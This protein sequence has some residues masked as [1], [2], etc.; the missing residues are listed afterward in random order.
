MMRVRTNTDVASALPGRRVLLYSV[1]SG[2][3]ALT[4]A[5]IWLLM[6]VDEGRGVA[7]ATT[8]MVVKFTN[9]TALLVGVVAGWIASGR[10][11]GELRAVGHLTVMLMAVVTAAV[12]A[13]VLDPSLPGGWWGAVDLCQ[14]Y[15]I[16]V[17]VVA[18]W[19]T[20]GPPVAV[21]R[22]RRALVLVVPLIWLVIVLVRGG[23]S[24]SYPYDF[25]DVAENGWPS[26]LTTVAALVAFILILG[27]LF[28]AIEVRL[29]PERDGRP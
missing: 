12:N 2:L 29:D 6:I 27:A 15:V 19:A 20:M 13:I 24:D 4:S 1:L 14:H 7:S 23:F 3:A 17:M 26:V 10:S 28:G 25:I 18:L 16:P 22:S 21:P 9:L 8:E 5:G 11:P